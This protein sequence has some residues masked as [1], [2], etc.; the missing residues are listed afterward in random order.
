MASSRREAWLKIT[1]DLDVKLLVVSVDEEDRV[2][3]SQ[4]AVAMIL[5]DSRRG[6]PNDPYYVQYPVVV[7]LLGNNNYRIWGEL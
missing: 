6:L 3:M 4:Q 2:V 7:E 5:G 1:P